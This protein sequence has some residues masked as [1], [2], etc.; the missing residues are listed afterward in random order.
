MILEVN[1]TSDERRIYFLKAPDLDF[2]ATNPHGTPKLTESDVAIDPDKEIQPATKFVSKWAKDFHVSPF[3]SRKGSYTLSAHDPFYPSLSGKGSINNLVELHSSK[4]HVKIVARIFST[5]ES[6]DP[7]LFSLLGRLKFIASWWWV[8]LVTF[9][10][11]VYEAGKLF[12]RRKLQVWYRP[13]VLKGSI[14]RHETRDE[15][16]IPDL[17]L[18]PPK[19]QTLSSIC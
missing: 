6:I 4:D 8:G 16:Y 5:T 10:R 12:F 11:V 1:N 19:T 14:G 15:R 3:N 17:V 2:T 7:S 13:E 9:P 18:S